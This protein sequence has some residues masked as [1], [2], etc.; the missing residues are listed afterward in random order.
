[1]SPVLL[2]TWIATT[3]KAARTR[4]DGERA[5]TVQGTGGNPL[6]SITDS[7]LGGASETCCPSMTRLTGKLV[8]FRR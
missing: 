7:P 6:A 1:M 5:V 3:V 8:P 4:P 2:S